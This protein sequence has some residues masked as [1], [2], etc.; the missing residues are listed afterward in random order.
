M[1]KS[2]YINPENGIEKQITLQDEV[3]RDAARAALDMHVSEAG[4]DTEYG[5]P[6]SVI[7]IDYG[8][9]MLTGQGDYDNAIERRHPRVSVEQSSGTKGRDAVLVYDVEGTHREFI[10]TGDRDGQSKLVGEDKYFV[11]TAKLVDKSWDFLPSEK[12]NGH[13]I[14]K[15]TESPTGISKQRII[16]GEVVKSRP[17]TKRTYVALGKLARIKSKEIMKK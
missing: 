5:T 16:N 4:Q 8:H 11:P 15:D 14:K 17:A 3:M 2:E 9:R 13:I 12:T 7:D 6:H 10:P 1:K